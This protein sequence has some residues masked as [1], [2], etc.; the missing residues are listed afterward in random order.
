MGEGSRQD[1][2]QCDGGQGKSVGRHWVLTLRTAAA[3]RD[4]H[5]TLSQ[6]R[7]K[8]KQSMGYAAHRRSRAI[9]VTRDR[10]AANQLPPPPPPK[11]LAVGDGLS[12]GAVVCRDPH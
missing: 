1:R 6:A 12:T 5:T 10:L 4:F 2:V 11:D 3:T 9:V 8:V 7:D